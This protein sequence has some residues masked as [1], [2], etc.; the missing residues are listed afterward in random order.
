MPPR[1]FSCAST[2]IWAKWNGTVISR[3]GCTARRS[4]YATTWA[5]SGNLGLTTD[6]DIKEGQKVVIGRMGIGKDQALF[7]VMTVKIVP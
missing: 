3:R 6:V 7:L 2:G 1:R 4:T 5:G